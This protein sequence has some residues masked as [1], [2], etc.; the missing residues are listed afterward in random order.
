MAMEAPVMFSPEPSKIVTIR[1]PKVSYKLAPLDKKACPDQDPANDPLMQKSAVLPI[2]LGATSDGTLLSYGSTCSDQLAVESWTGSGK[3]S[4]ITILP[5]QKTGPE[6]AQILTGAAKDAWL[7]ADTLYHYDGAA[8]KEHDDPPGGPASEG[9]VA[10]D[11]T[12]WVIG[13]K[14]AVF[15]LQKDTW[16]PEPLPGGA[17]AN[18]L[19]VG[20]D[21]TV[22]IT[23]AKAL[24]RSRRQNDGEG[25]KV[26]PANNDR[27]ARKKHVSPGSPRCSKNVAVLYGFTKVTPDDYDFPLTRKAL[28]GH[29]EFEKARFV[30]TKDAGQKFFTALVPDYAMGKKLVALIEKEVQGA[31]PALV[32]A[33]P[34]IVREVKIDL[35][36]GNVVK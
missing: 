15:A 19:A 30:V 23:T 27:P 9:A 22:W 7:L 31:K 3:P 21:G 11:G 16:R 32:C 35:A 13:A 5:R 8:W 17:A 18:H 2:A 29:K 36:T 20:K 26:D 6:E 25:V 10:P 1:G 34:E 4:T 33:E 14:G 12:L 24:L 28:K